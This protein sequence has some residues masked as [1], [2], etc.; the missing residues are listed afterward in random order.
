MPEE[1]PGKSIGFRWL[2]LGAIALAIGA[3]YL[4][5]G[6]RYVSFTFIREHLDAI[7]TW[8]GEHFFLAVGGFFVIYV[9]VTALSLP[10]ATMLSLLGGAILGR[11][12]GTA[13]C[14]TA[15]TCGATF[16]M[17]GSRYL[18]RDL[19]RAKFGSKLDALDQG[20]A[21]DGVYYLFSLRLAPFIPFFLINLGIG[22][23]NFRATTFFWVSFVGMMPGAFLFN[24]AGQA[25]GDL[26]SPEGIVSWQIVLALALLGVTP[27]LFKWLLS[28]RPTGR[29]SR[30]A[31]SED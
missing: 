16:A 30:N 9:G 2:L 1:V 14:L 13:V 3:F 22:L 8:V 23:T 17:L 26:E 7:R 19:V 5:G 29:R 24:N 11:W 21:K 18:F 6:D 20:I 12:L 27:L 31:A 28:G 25:L 4:L 15:A 10:V